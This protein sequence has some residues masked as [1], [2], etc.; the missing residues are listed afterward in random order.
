[1]KPFLPIHLFASLQV[2]G[3]SAGKLTAFLVHTWLC[4]PHP[5]GPEMGSPRPVCASP[6]QQRQPGPSIPASSIQTRGLGEH[7]ARAEGSRWL[8]GLPGW[9]ALLQVFQENQLVRAVR[10]SGP[11]SEPGGP[12]SLPIPPQGGPCLAGPAWTSADSMQTNK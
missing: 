11:E 1:M 5:R 7:T 4:F 6:G 10:G 8:G 3:F 9:T 2:Q 12:I